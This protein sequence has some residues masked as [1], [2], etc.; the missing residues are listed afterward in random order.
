[1]SKINILKN[2]RLVYLASPYTKYYL[3]QEVAFEQIAVYAGKLIQ[4]GVAVYA[5]IVHTHPIAT[6]SN[7]DP[8]NHDVWLPIDETMMRLADALCV[9]TMPGWDQSDGIAHERMFFRR[10]NKP[11]Y[12]I[13][14]EDL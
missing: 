7:L 3:G 11:E 13:A 8:G 4:H 9:V 5:P 1:M 2:Y 12:F 10:Q 6:R 14:P